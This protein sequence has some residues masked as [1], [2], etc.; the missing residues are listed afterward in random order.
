MDGLLGALEGLRMDKVAAEDARDLTPY[1]LDKPAWRVVLGLADGTARTLEIGSS[2]AE[3]QHH[4][5][6]GSSRLVAVIPDAVVQ[7]LGMI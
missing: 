5:R 3:K 4:A 7:D 2:P 6:E 1:G